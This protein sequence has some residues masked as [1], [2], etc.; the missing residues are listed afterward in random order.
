MPKSCVASTSRET[1]R[2][3]PVRPQTTASEVLQMLDATDFDLP[4]PQPPQLKCSERLSWVKR[5]RRGQHVS[6]QHGGSVSTRVGF[7]EGPPG[8]ARDRRSACA[9]DNVLRLSPGREELVFA[10][11]DGPGMTA[12]D[13]LHLHS[14]VH[15][16]RTPRR[17]RHDR[18]IA[19][20]SR[21]EHEGTY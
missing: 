2:I 9:H 11:A 13:V 5:T 19:N 15:T 3:D 14:G 12:I 18:P 20:I 10:S 21:R 7:A 16:T 6:F 17:P 8:P 1:C 4:C